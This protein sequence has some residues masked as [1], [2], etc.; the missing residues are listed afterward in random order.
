M[1]ERA[2]D[3]LSRIEHHMIDRAVLLLLVGDQRVVIVEIEHAKVFGL[4]VGEAG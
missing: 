2:L 3:H 1:L 4:L